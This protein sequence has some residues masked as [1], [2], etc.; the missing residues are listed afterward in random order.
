MGAYYFY[1]CLDREEYFSAGAL[2]GGNKRSALGRGL[3]SRAFALLVEE[4]GSAEAA[5]GALAGVKPGRWSGC[6]VATI[7]DEYPAPSRLLPEAG[8]GLLPFVEDRFRDIGSS[9]AMM[10][11]EIDG[12]ALLDAAEASESFLITL[13]ELAVVHHQVPVAR[14]LEARF[15]PEWIKTYTRRRKDWRFIVPPP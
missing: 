6:R 8:D 12:N 2:G 3:E 14:A 4:P 13:A 9:V 15:G 5:A 11:L 7:N 1:V 10:M